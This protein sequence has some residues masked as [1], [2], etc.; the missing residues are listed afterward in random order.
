MSSGI[1]A[2]R[3]KLQDAFQVFNQVSEQLADSYQQ[4]ELKVSKLSEELAAA[5]SERMVELAE[6]ERLAN[7]LSKLLDTLPAA[8]IVVGGDGRVQ[9]FN[10]AAQKLFPRINTSQNWQTLAEDEF[11]RHGPGDEIRLKSGR[12]VSLTER[13]LLP[14]SGR[15]LLLLDITE[16][17]ELQSRVERQQRLS[18]MG[19]MSAQLAHQ[20]RTPLSSVLLYNA[21][22]ARDDLTPEQRKRFSDHCRT[23]LMHIERQI[24]DMLSFARGQRYTPEPMDIALLLGDLRQTLTPLFEYQ[25]TNAQLIIEIESVP[26]IGGN[27][28]ALIGA[29]ANLAINALEHG[30]DD[31]KLV[32]RAYRQGQHV[33]IRFEDNGPGIPVD[34]RQRIFDPFYT[35]RSDG[36]GLGLAVVQSVV[37]AHQG[38]IE[39]DASKSGGASFILSFPALD[40]SNNAVNGLT[41]SAL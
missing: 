10:P 33:K 40:S 11:T 21:H 38:E 24:N 20:V 30:G 22:L 37:L 31:V 28:D 41:R 5:R 19:E 39:V 25:G 34:V 12:L 2:E 7:R 17:R 4:L 6:K 16:T 23:R 36:T 14:E 35:T 3:Q 13:S 32:I 29:F 18:A 8:V 26:P 1:P 9:E 15:I 27:K